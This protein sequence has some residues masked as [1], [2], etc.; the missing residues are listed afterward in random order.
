M[1][2]GSE[3]AEE[4]FREMLAEFEVLL[5][6]DAN[7]A[8]LDYVV[9]QIHAWLGDQ[10]RAVAYAEELM[11][12]EGF[13]FWYDEFLWVPAMFDILLVARETD[14]FLVE[15]DDYLSG[16]G[17]WSIEALSR[18]PRLDYLRNDPRFKGIVEKH[19]RQ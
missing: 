15:L 3:A 9:E 17:S 4:E 18:D 13:G 11:K 16:P 8:D 12:M 1:E 19:R 10:A 14:R 7:N 2:D 5:A 6:E